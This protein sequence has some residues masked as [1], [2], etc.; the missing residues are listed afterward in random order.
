LIQSGP[1]YN[2]PDA[3]AILSGLRACV[4]PVFSIFSRPVDDPNSVMLLV[5]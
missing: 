4:Y 2:S 5:S 3:G 1:V